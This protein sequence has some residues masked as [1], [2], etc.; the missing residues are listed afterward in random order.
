MTV[1]TYREAL[2]QSLEAAMTADPSVIVNGKIMLWCVLCV[3][4]VKT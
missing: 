4:L 3:H 1:T 2:R